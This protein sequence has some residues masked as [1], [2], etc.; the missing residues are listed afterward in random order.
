ME[1]RKKKGFK[2]TAKRYCQCEDCDDEDGAVGQCG[3]CGMLYCEGCEEEHELCVRCGKFLS[4]TRIDYPVSEEEREQQMGRTRLKSRA[5]VSAERILDIV[6]CRDGRLFP[7]G[8]M[9]WN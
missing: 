3:N 9:M 2:K 7:M 8:D 6:R 5:I 4:Q 1:K